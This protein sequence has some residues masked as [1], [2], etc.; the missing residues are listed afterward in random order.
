MKEIAEGCIFSKNHHND[1]IVAWMAQSHFWFLGEWQ[2]CGIRSKI[3]IKV[4]NITMDENTMND[5]QTTQP[6]SDDQTPATEAPAT[7]APVTETPADE[8]TPVAE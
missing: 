5:D 4:C 8:E 3:G 2:I 1:C 7:E 6:M